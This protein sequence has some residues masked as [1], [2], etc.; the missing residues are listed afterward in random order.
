MLPH[1]FLKKK[2]QKQSPELS[3]PEKKVKKSS[4]TVPQF[5]QP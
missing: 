5:G 2:V 1:N 3:L 4:K